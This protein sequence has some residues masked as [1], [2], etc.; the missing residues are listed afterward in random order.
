MTKQRTALGQAAYELGREITRNLAISGL[1]KLVRAE[2]PK[3]RT[4]GEIARIWG[5][6][7]E[8]TPAEIDAIVALEGLR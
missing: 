3:D 4:L 6:E 2:Y 8:L 7:A 1:T 5:S